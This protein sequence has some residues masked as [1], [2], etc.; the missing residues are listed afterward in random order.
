LNLGLL[1]MTKL[2]HLISLSG[3]DRKTIHNIFDLSESFLKVNARDVKK[4]PLLRGRTVCNL[5]F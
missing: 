5:F 2:N 4:V 1:N 3:L